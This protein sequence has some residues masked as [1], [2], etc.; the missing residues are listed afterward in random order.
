MSVECVLELDHRV[1]VQ[2]SNSTLDV[3]S[4]LLEL[5]SEGLG[6][7]NGLKLVVYVGFAQGLLHNELLLG[8]VGVNSQVIGRS[9]GTADTFNPSVRR[10]NL[11]VPAVLEEKM[12]FERVIHAA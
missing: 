6:L 3:S 5:H 10:L 2:S 9:V 7:E 8:L 11:K 4:L 1:I 12:P